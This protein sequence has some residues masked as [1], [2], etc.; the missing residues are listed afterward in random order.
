MECYGGDI[1]SNNINEIG[2]EVV[3]LLLLNLLCGRL[4][5]VHGCV[6]AAAVFSVFVRAMIIINKHFADVA[7]EYEHVFYR[8]HVDNR[9]HMRCRCSVSRNV[10]DHLQHHQFSKKTWRIVSP[11]VVREYHACKQSLL[12]G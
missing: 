1:T 8:V 12:V 7:G 4:W 5:H 3:L 10:C 2:V 9:R 6:D 11:D